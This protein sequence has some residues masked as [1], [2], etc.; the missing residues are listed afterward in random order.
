MYLSSCCRGIGPHL[1]LKWDLG[2]HFELQQGSQVS[3]QVEGHGAQLSSHVV[4]RKS[5]LL[6]S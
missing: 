3:S 5:G 1:E 6:S 4:T 2:V